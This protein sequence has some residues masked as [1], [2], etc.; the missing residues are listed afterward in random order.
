[1]QSNGLFERINHCR[2]PLRYPPAGAIHRAFSLVLRSLQVIHDHL[3][4]LSQVVHLAAM[5]LKC[6]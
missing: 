6:I 3:K 2:H 4:H 1:M 5:A